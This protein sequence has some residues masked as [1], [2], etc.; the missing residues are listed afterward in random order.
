MD[1][2]NVDKSVIRDLL[3]MP[4]RNFIVN[5]KKSLE[6]QTSFLCVWD[7]IIIIIIIIIII[8][9]GIYDYMLQ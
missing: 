7:H 8:V 5:N 2:C 9:Q 3:E 4:E 6:Y 1:E